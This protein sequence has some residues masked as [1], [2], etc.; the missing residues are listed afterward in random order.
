LKSSKDTGVLFKPISIKHNI[1]NVVAVTKDA[2]DINCEPFTPMFL[3]KNPEATELTNGKM[4][5][6]KHI[7]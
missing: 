1:A 2:H 6:A 7:I 3:P 5:I 4:I